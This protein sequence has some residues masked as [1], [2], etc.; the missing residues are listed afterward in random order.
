[1]TGSLRDRYDD[2]IDGVLSCYDRVVITGTLPTVCYAAGMTRF[3]YAKQ[4]RIFDYPAFAATM[5]ERVASRAAEAG[6]TI[7]HIAK[8]HIRKEAVVA[9]G[10][11]L[12]TRGHWS[13]NEPAAKRNFIHPDRNRRFQVERR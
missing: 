3:L 10:A 4:M 2:R 1:M 9:K 8:N 12:R 11:Y 5:R 7:E 6:I 13:A